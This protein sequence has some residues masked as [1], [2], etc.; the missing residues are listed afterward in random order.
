M[1]HDSDPTSNLQAAN[2]APAGRPGG[3]QDMVG[4]ALWL[5]SKAGSFMD[6]KIVRIEG[7]RLLTLRGVLS[8]S[9]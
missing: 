7:G 2:E 4:T 5:A 8:N 3:I 1:C 9:D 6:G